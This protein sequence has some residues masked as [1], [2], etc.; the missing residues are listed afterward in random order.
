[1]NNAI[2]LLVPRVRGRSQRKRASPVSGNGVAAHIKLS[3][4]R[5]SLW[6]DSKASFPKV[7]TKIAPP[8]A[9]RPVLYQLKRWGVVFVHKGGRGRGWLVGIGR[10]AGPE[11]GLVRPMTPSP[12]QLSCHGTQ[13]GSAVQ[14]RS[15]HRK[16]RTHAASRSSARYITLLCFR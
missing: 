5:Q 4:N 15:S 6:I 16:G 1:M 14:Y 13:T 3:I 2:I 8:F 9:V 12:P 11:A 7:D 10:Q